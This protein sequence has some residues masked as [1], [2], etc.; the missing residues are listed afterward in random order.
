M[1]KTPTGAE[2]REVQ[3]GAIDQAIH[4]LEVSIRYLQMRKRELSETASPPFVRVFP[5]RES[6]I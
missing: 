5:P 4:E 3:V 2:V 6:S 1:S